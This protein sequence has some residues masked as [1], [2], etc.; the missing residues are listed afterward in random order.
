ME[1]KHTAQV[2]I[3]VGIIAFAWVITD[4]VMSYQSTRPTTI[5]QGDCRPITRAQSTGTIRC[6]S[7]GVLVYQNSIYH[8]GGILCSTDGKLIKITGGKSLCVIESSQFSVWSPPIGD[9]GAK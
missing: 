9:E 7:G 5:T 4:T 2:M 6:W 8:N 1:S 3:V